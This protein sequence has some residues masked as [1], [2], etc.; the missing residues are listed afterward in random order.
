MD[1]MRPAREAIAMEP[2]VKSVVLRNKVRLQYVE[3]GD[4]S[5]VP[6]VLL[7]GYVDSWRSF[8]RVL[9]R[10]PASLHV[11]AL[12]QRGHGD[13]ERPAGSYGSGDFAADMAGFM[14]AL[15]LGPAVIAGHS[16]GSFAAQRFALD[17]PGRALG[18]VLIGSSVAMQGNPVWQE[19]GDSVR[20]L[21]DPI[22]PR[23]VREFQEST[24]AQPIPPAF[25]DT[26]VQESL[27][28]PARVW[29]AAWES[30]SETD[31]SK[32]LGRIKAPTLIAWGGND[33]L[34]PREEQEALLDAIASSRL[35]LYANAGHA[36]HWEEPGRF[37]SDLT[38]FIGSIGD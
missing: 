30:L 27:K 11:L 33:A 6:V 15:G 24:L 34:F 13:S 18:L 9:P 2:E 26:V 29:K 17:F 37:A 31:W 21:A 28:V 35:V 4:P 8:E 22:D 16:M 32:E 10:L 5:G 23:F 12:S 3:Q 7:H 36:L 19:L 20:K 25:L 38:A 14:E 1:G